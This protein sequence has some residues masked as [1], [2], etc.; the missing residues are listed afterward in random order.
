MMLLGDGRWNA[1]RRPLGA[2]CTTG[3]TVMLHR[4]LEELFKVIPVGQHPSINSELPK[5]SNVVCV[6]VLSKAQC[7]KCPSALL[8]VRAMP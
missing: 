1:S 5:A 7:P 2:M 8:L 6:V 3:C 4:A